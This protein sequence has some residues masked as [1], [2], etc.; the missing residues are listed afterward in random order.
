M[1]T[2]KSDTEL[3]SPLQKIVTFLENLSESVTGKLRKKRKVERAKML[4]RINDRQG[5]SY[6]EKDVFG[7]EI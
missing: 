6:T 2:Q 5:K 4:G 7:D 3:A 1:E